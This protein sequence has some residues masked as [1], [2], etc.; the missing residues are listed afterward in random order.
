LQYL[1][2]KAA[3][4]RLG[5]SGQADWFEGTGLLATAFEHRTSRAGDPQIHTHVLV[6]N[7][8]R[9]PDGRWAALDGRLLYAESKTAGCVHE[10]A[11][12][13]A[14]VAEL[15]TARGVARAAAH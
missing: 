12:R 2:S 5:A 10:A 14:L 13:R 7:A 3:H 11:F 9:R 6:A 4:G 8:V 15:R 1:E